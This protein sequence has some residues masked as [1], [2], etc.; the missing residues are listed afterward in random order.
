M[1]ITRTPFIIPTRL[2]WLGLLAVIGFCGFIAQVLL[3]MGLQ[4][5]TAGRGTMAVYT[6]IVFATILER[7]FFHTSP[8][9]LSVVGTVIIISSALYVALTKKKEVEAGDSV[10]L[11]RLDDASLEE[12]LLDHSRI[13]DS[14]KTRGHQ[15][16]SKSEEVYVLQSGV[17]SDH[18]DTES[19]KEEDS[20]E[21][22]K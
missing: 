1:L 8:P 7:I 15:P 9:P 10:S 4:R 17:D 18:E 5:E 20:E 12:G 16:N 2:L 6:Q 13:A 11:Q 19:E 22:S 21:A 3:T 14:G